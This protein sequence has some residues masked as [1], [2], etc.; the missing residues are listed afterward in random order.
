MRA[1]LNGEFFTKVKAEKP[2]LAQF[3]D[4]NPFN[5]PSFEDLVQV[6][7]AI[8]PSLAETE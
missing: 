4:P 5:R 7:T 1:I 8:D 2:E 3:F 6:V